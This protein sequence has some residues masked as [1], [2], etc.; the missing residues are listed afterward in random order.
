MQALNKVGIA[1]IYITTH[2]LPIPQSHNYCVETALQN[3][4]IQKIF[5]I[6]EDNFLFPDAFVA[7]ATSEYDITALQYNDKNGSPHGIIHYDGSGEI[8]WCGLGATCIKREVFE[9]LGAPYFR[10][11]T[12]Y[13][14]KKK[15]VEEGKTI[16]DFE[17]IEPRQEWSD[18]ENRMIEVKDEYKYGGLDVDFYTRARKQGYSIQTL[19]AFKAHHFQLVELGKPHTNQGVHT[20]RQV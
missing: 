19:P 2:D 11:D 20:I 16:T 3:S 10:T 1:T 9:T 17:P 8:L 5:F 6:E 4:S 12:R 7:V 14:I 15:Y 18:I 13:K